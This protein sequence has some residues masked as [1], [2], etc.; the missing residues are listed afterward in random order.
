MN[1]IILPNVR[2]RLSRR[3]KWEQR[4][5]FQ[6]IR[7]PAAHSLNHDLT[8]EATA[9]YLIFASLLARRLD[10]AKILKRADKGKAK[11]L[12]LRE[13]MKRVGLI[14]DSE[15]KRTQARW[16]KLFKKL[17][18][19]PK[20]RGRL[21]GP[22]LSVP[23]VGYDPSA[24]SS[25]LLVGQVTK[26]DWY[27]AQHRKQPSVTGRR[28]CTLDYLYNESPTNRGAFWTFAR[29]LSKELMEGDD[30]GN[31]LRNLVWTNVCK[32]G[33]LRACNKTAE[34]LIL[35]GEVA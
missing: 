27:L 29:E 19:D 23:P 33:D 1:A 35:I 14:D 20:L 11:E 18:A 24:H 5:E 2:Y 6:G 21:A 16:L 34:N 10:A 12:I 17:D 28:R 31:G 7:N 8:A 26:G 30:L 22:F 9:Q 15:L 13:T 4:C 32:L 3:G 25:V